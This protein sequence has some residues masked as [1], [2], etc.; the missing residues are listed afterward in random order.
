MD[1]MDENMGEET[2]SKDYRG[3]IVVSNE[4]AP[5]YLKSVCEKALAIV[6]ISMLKADSSQVPY[7]CESM[8][9]FNGRSCRLLTEE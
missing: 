1:T 6:L 3:I 8:M 9:K 5:G 7:P 2:D 4:L